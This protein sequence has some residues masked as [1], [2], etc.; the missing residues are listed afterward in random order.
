MTT[1]NVAF[2]DAEFTAKSEKDRGVQEMIQCALIVCQVV[3]S[4]ENKL[5]SV[6]DEPLFTYSAFVKPTYNKQL[7]EYIKELTGIRQGDVDAGKD[8]CEVVRDLYD[9]VKLFNIAEIWTWG[10]DKILFKNNCNVVDCDRRKTRV[11]HNRF[12]DVSIKMSD[13]FG[14]DVAI[15]QHKVCKL[16][17][18]DEIG[19]RHDACADAINLFRIF[20]ELG[21]QIYV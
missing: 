18:I 1:R 19:N 2:F 9:A 17:G 14:Y 8:Y 6:A 11:I 16:L 21:G 15:A 12:K 20:K 3:V 13:Y 4:E 10:P 7:S 5:I